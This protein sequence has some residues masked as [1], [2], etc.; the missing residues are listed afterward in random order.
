[1]SEITQESTH[2]GS[3]FSKFSERLKG[4]EKK[5]KKEKKRREKWKKVSNC[6]CNFNKIAWIFFKF[7]PEAKRNLLAV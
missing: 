6:Y 5:L 7:A 2:D 4:R 3:D 1:M